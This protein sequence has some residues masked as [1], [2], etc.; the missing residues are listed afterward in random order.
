MTFWVGVFAWL[1]IACY[2]DDNFAP[3]VT[4]A[5]AAQRFGGLTQWV[6]FGKSMFSNNLFNGSQNL[7]YCIT[8][9]G[10]LP[11]SGQGLCW[12]RLCLHVPQ[13]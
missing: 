11:S 13:L 2:Y 6:A 10:A 1:V 12:V 4:G 8:C 9:G 5:E 3:G 7:T